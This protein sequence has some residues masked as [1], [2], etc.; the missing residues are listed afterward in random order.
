MEPL[1]NDD[2]IS[3]LPADKGRSTFLL[4]RTEHE[5]NNLTPVLERK[6]NNLMLALKKSGALPE[7][8]YYRLRSSAG[9]TPQFYGLPKVHKP[10]RPLRPIVSFINSPTYQLSKHLVSLLSPLVYNSSSYVANS[11]DFATFIKKHVE[12]L[13]YLLMLCHYLRRYQWKGL[14]I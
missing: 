11:F 12:Q 8:L 2:S 7:V 14:Q 10:G 1:Q 3:I 6:M 13:W 5:I 4:D 9:K